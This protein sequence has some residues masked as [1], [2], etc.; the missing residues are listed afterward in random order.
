MEN[1]TL[2]L[3][4]LIT[5]SVMVQSALRYVTPGG[6]DVANDCLDETSP[7]GTLIHVVDNFAEADDTIFLSNG[8]HEVSPSS[9]ILTVPL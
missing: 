5:Q 9:V 4:F 6:I 3:L 7:C 1:R 2:G 8:V